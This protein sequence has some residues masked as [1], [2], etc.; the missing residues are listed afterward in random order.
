[1]RRNAIYSSLIFHISKGEENVEAYKCF[2]SLGSDH[3]VLT[4]KIKLS[5]R[6]RQSQPRKVRYDWAVFKDPYL[7]ILYTVTVKN[8]YSELTVP[9][10][11]IS[12]EYG[13]FV[14]TNKEAAQKLIPQK[15]KN[16]RKE[17]VSAKHTNAARKDV[18]DAFSVYQVTPASENQL[19]LQEAKEKLSILYVAVKEEELEELIQK[20]EESD[21]TYRHG[22]SWRLITEI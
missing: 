22:Q 11:D 2:S 10:D 21:L 4:A 13:K 14:K 16:R 3:R 1:M 8:R 15:K 12:Q 19:K 20:I 9:E 7:Q 18:Q 17:V 5:V 6:M